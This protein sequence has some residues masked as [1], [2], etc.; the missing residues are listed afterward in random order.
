MATNYTDE[1]VERLVTEYNANPTRETVE[2]LA[3]ELDRTTRS[4]ISKL[5]NLGVYKA[6][7]A[8]KASKDTVRKSDIVAEVSSYVGSDL[9]S[10]TKATKADL[11]LLVKALRG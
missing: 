5:S 8:A 4:V 10:L 9:E 1:M 7:K 11:E 2:N 6:E 3:E